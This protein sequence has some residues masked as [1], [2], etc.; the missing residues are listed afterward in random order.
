MRKISKFIIIGI[1]LPIVFLMGSCWDNRE[2]DSIAIVTGIGID[3]AEDTDKQQYLLQIQKAQPTAGAS[4]GGSQKGDGEQS[5]GSSTYIL[6]N[7]N[8]GLI[9]AVNDLRKASTRDLY[10]NH[11]QIL[12]IG[13]DRAKYCLRPEIDSFLREHELRME[14][15]VMMADETAES[16]F[17]AS[18]PQEPNTSMGLGRMMQD[19]KI[20]TKTYSINLLDFISKINDKTTAPVLPIIAVRKTDNEDYFEIT[21]LAVF[22][23]TCKLAGQ[24]ELELVRGYSWGHGDYKMAFLNIDCEYG[25]FT[26]SINAIKTKEKS[27]LSQTG[28]PGL[29]LEIQGKFA[30]SEIKGFKDMTLEEITPIVQRLTNEAIAEKIQKT[31]R[32]SQSINC[33]IFEIGNKCSRHY[34]KEWETIEPRW[35]QIYPETFIN[36]KANMKFVSTGKGLYSLE[37]KDPN[38]D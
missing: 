17:N 3:A 6:K 7:T 1:V 24:L 23:K 12:V 2:L 16:V 22:D 31:F 11:N 10:L 38:D 28:V 14:I 18:L 20:Y 19:E 5:G 8:L 37:M 33:D 29:E 26:V 34:P 13:R 15:W 30:L 4:K 32:Y 21:G 27:V 9:S 35:Q 36:A 25:S